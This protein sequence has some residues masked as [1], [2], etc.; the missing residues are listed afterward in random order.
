VQEGHE[1]GNA[2]YGTEGVLILGK[3]SGWQLFG[4]K[5]KLIEEGRGSPDLAA[6]HRDF[7]DCIRQGGQPHAEIEINHLSSALCH[8]GNIA[9]RFGRVLRF[10]P[11]T[12]QV[13]NDDESHRLLRRDYR[14]THWAA[15]L[16]V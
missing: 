16:G 15:P 1:N 12:E 2:F 7:L 5:N 10:D 3:Q 13:L 8:L 9:T 4:P 14:D 6:H 11:A